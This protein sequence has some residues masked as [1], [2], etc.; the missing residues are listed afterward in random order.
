MLLAD[1]ITA[2]VFALIAIWDMADGIIK[3]AK[4]KR[5]LAAR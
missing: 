2:G 1:N 3:A 4:A 5:R